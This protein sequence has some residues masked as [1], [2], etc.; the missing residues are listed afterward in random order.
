MT[1]N[2]RSEGQRNRVDFPT[3]WE[4]R[5]TGHHKGVNKHKIGKPAGSHLQLAGNYD[6][7]TTLADGSAGMIPMGHGCSMAINWR[8]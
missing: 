1:D 2:K 6:Y 3:K 5:R 4:Q 7:S 8:N